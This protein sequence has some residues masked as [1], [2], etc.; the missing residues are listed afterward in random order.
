MEDT[1]FHLEII[2]PEKILI[3]EDVDSIELPGEQGEFQVLTGHTPFLTTLRIGPIIITKGV[4]KSFV[5]ISGGYCE[6]LPNKT[7]ILAHTAETADKID[8]A[9]AETARKRAE[10]RL[11]DAAKDMTIDEARAKLA[12]LRA[13]NRLNTTKMK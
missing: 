9:R 4:K 8:K 12:L 11:E 6:V 1:R 5:S 2:T 10:K 3:S 7:T 13:L